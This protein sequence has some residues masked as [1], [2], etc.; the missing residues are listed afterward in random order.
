MFCLLYVI[1]PNCSKRKKIVAIL[2]V[3]LFP[4]SSASKIHT[5]ERCSKSKVVLSSELR[6]EECQ[7][8]KRLRRNTKTQT[9]EATCPKAA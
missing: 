1:G 7:D 8:R 2:E 9:D 3:I 6:V 4:F 5:D